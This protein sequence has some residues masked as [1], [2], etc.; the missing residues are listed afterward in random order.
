MDGIAEQDR[1]IALAIGSF[2]EEEAAMKGERDKV[3]EQE[4]ELKQ[5]QVC[6]Q[7][8]SLSVL[9]LTTVVEYMHGCT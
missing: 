4:E 3:A 6:K 7:S 5:L 1:E 9:H 2:E 8:V